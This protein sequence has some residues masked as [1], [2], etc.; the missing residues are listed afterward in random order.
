MKYCSYRP[1]PEATYIDAFSISW[2]DL[3]FYCFPPFN[4]I[5]QAL[6]KD[7]SG[8]SNRNTGCPKLANSALVS[9]S[10]TSPSS[11]T[12]DL[13]PLLNTFETASGSRGAAS[14]GKETRTADMSCIREKLQNSGLPP[15]S[16]E[17][18]MASWRKGTKSQYQTYLTKWSRFCDTTNCEFFNPPIP[19]I[20]SFLT[21]LFD[22]GLSYSAINSARSALST[23]CQTDNAT[24]P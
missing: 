22:S 18:I 7:K 12:L 10:A 1:D 17:I 14:V 6:P 8:E 3:D 4:C 11:T 21:G 23:L 2:G 19:H 24:L 16:V 20:I 9:F 5:L 13:S 15:K